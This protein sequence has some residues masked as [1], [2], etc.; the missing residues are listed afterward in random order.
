MVPFFPNWGTPSTSSAREAKRFSAP[1]GGNAGCGTATNYGR[2][3]GSHNLG[4]HHCLKPRDRHVLWE[5]S[6]WPWWG[7]GFRTPQNIEKFITFYHPWS[8]IAVYARF[9]W[10]FG[11]R[12]MITGPSLVFKE[13]SFVLSVPRWTCSSWSCLSST[14]DWSRLSK[15]CT[16]KGG[17]PYNL[18]VSSTK[19]Q[20]GSSISEWFRLKV[21][22]LIVVLRLQF[23]WRVVFT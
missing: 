8:A 10:H 18:E 22:H 1:D 7:S 6:D 2:C 11:H 9:F 14:D 13:S 5:H 3:G 4:N 21:E 17:Q 12:D 19:P 23:G 16:S 20:L 15:G